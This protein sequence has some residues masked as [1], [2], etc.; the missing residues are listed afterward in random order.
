MGRLSIVAVLALSLLGSSAAFATVIYEEV[1][2]LND[3]PIN[4]PYPILAL[5]SGTNSVIGVASVSAD[6]VDNFAFSIPVGAKLT[7]ITYSFTINAFIRGGASLTDAVSG[8]LLVSGDGTGPLPASILAA[9]NIDMLPGL[10]SPLVPGSCA[11]ALTEV[12]LIEAAL[13]MT[14]GIYSFEQR[15]LTVNDPEF[16]SWVSRYQ[17]DLVVAGAD[18]TPTPVPEPG[19]LLLVGS[20]LAGLAGLAHRRRRKKEGDICSRGF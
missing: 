5:N 20:S 17:V 3:L 9:Q 18:A 11:A 4:P 13:P 12:I 15:A 6:A 10:C 7:S 14:A 19:T 16:V 2:N 8:F 1:T